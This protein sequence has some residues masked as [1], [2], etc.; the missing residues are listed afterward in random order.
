[1]IVAFCKG[2]QC[3]CS[4]SHVCIYVGP[5]EK[6]LS[7][8]SWRSIIA[9]RPAGSSIYIQQRHEE[10]PEDDHWWFRV[11]LKF[12]TGDSYIPDPHLSLANLRS[13]IK[14]SLGPFPCYTWVDLRSSHISQQQH[15]QSKIEPPPA[16]IPSPSCG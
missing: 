10:K 16:P 14:A 4:K 9:A 15:E 13:A 7:E 12:G 2:L 6:E 1:M 3:I 5:V 8:T 11:Q